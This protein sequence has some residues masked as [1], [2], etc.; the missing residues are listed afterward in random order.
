[1]EGRLEALVDGDLIAGDEFVGFVG[2]ANDGVKF[3]EHR[4]RHAFGEGRGGVRGDAILAIVRDADG[5]VQEFLGEGVESARSHDGFEVLPG[6]FEESGIVGDG[7]P[8]I[9]DVIGFACGHDVVVD[10]LDLR[11]GIRVFDE[12]ESRHKRLRRETGTFELS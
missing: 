5:E 4:G 9:V 2:H 1:M 6:A 10:G 11:A 12:T 7:F 3:L 8:E